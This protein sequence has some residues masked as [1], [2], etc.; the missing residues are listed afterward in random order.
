VLVLAGAGAENV[1]AGGA[2]RL[3]LTTGEAVAILLL[4]F[5]AS[6]AERWIQE[7]LH[8]Q[9]ITARTFHALALFIRGAKNSHQQTGKRHAGAPGAVY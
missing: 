1:G 8:T 5:G 2:C 4:A 9:D 6:C 3:A 7:R